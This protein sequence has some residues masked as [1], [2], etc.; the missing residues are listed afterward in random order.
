MAKGSLVP[1]AEL[2]LEAPETLKGQQELC[3]LPGTRALS[4]VVAPIDLWPSVPK[5]STLDEEKRLR[6]VASLKSGFH[7]HR[8]SR[9]PEGSANKLP[10]PD[11][12][13]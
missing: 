1:K 10:S 6:E 7:S 5:P 12:P 3:P 8:I 11:I 9:G 4:L 13:P 2:K